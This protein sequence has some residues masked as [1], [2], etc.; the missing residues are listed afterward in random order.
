MFCR[1]LAYLSDG[2]VLRCVRAEHYVNAAGLQRLYMR[3]Q[4]PRATVPFKFG[5]RMKNLA[6]SPHNSSLLKK[7]S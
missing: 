2:D 6:F 3:R 7:V 5:T 1:M 4:A